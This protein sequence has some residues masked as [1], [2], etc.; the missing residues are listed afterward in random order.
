MIPGSTNS[1]LPD[2]PVLGHSLASSATGTSLAI[3]DN[4]M[5]V[6]CLVTDFIF[7][8]VV[9]DKNTVGKCLA[10]VFIFSLATGLINMAGKCLIRFWSRFTMG[11]AFGSDYRFYPVV[12]TSLPLRWNFRRS[13]VT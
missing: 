6:K 5:A 1:L 7:C 3:V 4:N 10:K 13:Y 2:W 9:R 8:M 12:M 11:L